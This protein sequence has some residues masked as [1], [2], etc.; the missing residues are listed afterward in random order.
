MTKEVEF[1]LEGTSVC[2][3]IPCYG[4]TVPIEFALN[5]SQ[6]AV[7]FH[8]M[9]IPFSVVSERENALIQ[10]VRN[11]LLT[12]F[13]KETDAKYLFF[14]DDDIIFEPEDF[15][16]IVAVATKYKVV[17]GAYPARREEP[18]FFVRVEDAEEL[19]KNEVGFIKSCGTGLGFCCI[20]REVLEKFVGT[21]EVYHDKGLD[22]YN[23]F[24]VEFRDGRFWGEDIIFFDE[25]N[26]MGYPV[27]I[28]P[29]SKLKHVMRKD[30]DYC[31]RNFL[32]NATIDPSKYTIQGRK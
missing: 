20:A 12:R 3:A 24:A 29:G 9:G 18:T 6:T 10:A 31:L 5:L 8:K 26:E 4:G 19:E 30:I 22:V 27:W 16:A 25:L 7:K 17:A 1:N 13:L 23:A 15:L 21:K 2:V 28:N 14:L 32:D 11:R